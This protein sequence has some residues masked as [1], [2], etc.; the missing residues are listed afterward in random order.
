MSVCFVLRFYVF[1]TEFVL[2]KV[3]HI[4]VGCAYIVSELCSDVHVGGIKM[5]MLNLAL[6]VIK[7]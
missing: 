6:C 7:N 1:V 5:L 4:I 2:Y 3:T